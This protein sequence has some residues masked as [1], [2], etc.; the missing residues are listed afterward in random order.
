MADD[1]RSFPQLLGDL[2]GDLTGL[3]RK[4]SELVRAEFSEKLGVLGKAAGEMAA[5]AICLLAA[6]LVLLQ[7]V[8]IG[9]SNIMGA[10]WA[11]LLVGVVVAIFG[12]VLVRAG[13]KAA[14]PSGLA[15]DRTIAQ[16]KK[17][18]HLVKEQVT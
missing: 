9:L 18:A 5:G 3:V 4:E 17:D 15:P 16:V 10:G 6:L 13:T 12:I 14:S 7:A 1:T 11:S 2:T 8:V